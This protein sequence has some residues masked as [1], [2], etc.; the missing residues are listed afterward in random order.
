MWRWGTIQF[1]DFEDGFQ[2]IFSGVYGSNDNTLRSRLS[3]ELTLVHVRW[4]K[5]WCVARDLNVVRF[6]GE[7]GM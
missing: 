2:G 5:A 4:N 6:P 1:H 7:I 3:A